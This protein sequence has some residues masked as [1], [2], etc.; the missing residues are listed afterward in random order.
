[1]HSYIDDEPCHELEKVI[2]VLDYSLVSDIVDNLGNQNKQ[3]NKGF[4]YLLSTGFPKLN[5]GRLNQMKFSVA[6]I[7]NEEI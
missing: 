3:K 6:I 1:M 5:Q 2:K 4:F 7:V